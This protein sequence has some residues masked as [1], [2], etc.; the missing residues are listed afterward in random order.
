MAIKKAR[1]LS[2][3]QLG[4]LVLSANDVLSADA[5]VIKQLVKNGQVDDTPAAVKF[6]EDQGCTAVEYAVPSDNAAARKVLQGEI[7]DLEEKLA[8]AADADKTALAA[9][10]AAKQEEL[11]AL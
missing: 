9:Q 1:I 8:A 2:A 11:A 7:S 10:L 5:A 4:A 6:C 3:M